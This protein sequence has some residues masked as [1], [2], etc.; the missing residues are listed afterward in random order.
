MDLLTG[1]NGAEIVGIVS[2]VTLGITGIMHSLDR[3][4]RK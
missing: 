1:L 2:V 3:R 4:L